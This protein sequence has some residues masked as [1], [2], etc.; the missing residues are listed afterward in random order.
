[1]RGQVRALLAK[2][3]IPVRDPFATVH[4]AAELKRLR[5]P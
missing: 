5:E 2:H 1:V 3:G 4:T